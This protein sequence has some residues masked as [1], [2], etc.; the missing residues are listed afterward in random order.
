V[1]V[2]LKKLKFIEMNDTGITATG[3]ARLKAAGIARVNREAR[4]TRMRQGL[5]LMRLDPVYSSGPV[6]SALS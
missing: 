2:G 5:N 1:L 4:A 3:E 6:A